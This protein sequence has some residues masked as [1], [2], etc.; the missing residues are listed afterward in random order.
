[1]SGTG[2]GAADG[3]AAA[4]GG[5]T[6]G[7]AAGCALGPVTPPAPAAGDGAALAAVFGGGEGAAGVFALEQAAA[8]STRPVRSVNRRR[9]C[10]IEAP[11]LLHEAC[12]LLALYGS[13]VTNRDF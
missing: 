8:T 7:E 12:E 10:G 13:R 6:A 1:M 2:L 4:A 11:G 3:A 9:G 5:G